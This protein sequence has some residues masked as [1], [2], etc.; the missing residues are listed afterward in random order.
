[1]NIAETGRVFAK[2]AAVDNRQTNDAAIMAWHEIL[3]D[4]E[5][6]DC[7]AAV[8]RHRTESPGVYLEPGHVRRLAKLIRDERT[9]GNEVKALPP[10][11]FEDD[12]DRVQRTKRNA[13][14]VRELLAQLAAKR[15]IEDDEAAPK[16]PPTR[17]ESIRSRALARA[18][19]E[20]RLTHP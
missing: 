10:G 18:R 17:S 2:A 16:G 15:S 3:R 9:K 11:R 14:R 6:S 4:Q 5:F 20:K 13:G 19:A 12:Q 1:M 8:T 7:L